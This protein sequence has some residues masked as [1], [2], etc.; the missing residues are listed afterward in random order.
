MLGLL[1]VH[2]TAWAQEEL[3]VDDPSFEEPP[4]EEPEEEDE[5]SEEKETKAESKE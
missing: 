3:P 2:S 4:P 5:K 1:V